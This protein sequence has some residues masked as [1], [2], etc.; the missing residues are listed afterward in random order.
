MFPRDA[1]KELVDGSAY[2]GTM[3]GRGGTVVDSARQAD[4]AYRRR[5]PGRDPFLDAV[6]GLTPAMP[7]ALD[8]WLDGFAPAAAAK[9][10]KGEAFDD[11]P[12]LAPWVK[13]MLVFQ[14]AYAYG[15]REAQ[16]PIAITH[17]CLS[18][19]ELIREVIREPALPFLRTVLVAQRDAVRALQRRGVDAPSLEEIGRDMRVAGALATFPDLARELVE[20]LVGSVDD[21]LTGKSLGLAARTAAGMADTSATRAAHRPKDKVARGFFAGVR[22]LYAQD[23]LGEPAPADL[24]DLALVGGLDR[25]SHESVREAWRKRRKKLLEETR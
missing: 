2:V 11:F 10:M 5:H 1:R 22:H 24:A 21:I 4:Q 14:W 6:A 19:P 17:P 13:G 20:R 23:G 15:R 12:R 16:Q 7:A 25:G 8:A 9:A 3:V 18:N